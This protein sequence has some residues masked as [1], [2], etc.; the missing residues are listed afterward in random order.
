M[1]KYIDKALDLITTYGP[2]ILLAIVVLLL[3]LWIINRIVKFTRRIMRKRNVD[4]SLQPFLASIINIGLK[5]LLLV[6]VAGMLGFATTSFVAII[7]AAGLAV[8]LALQGTL[9]NFAGGVLILLF[10][11]IR[12][13]DLIEA[14]G[15]FGNVEEIQIFVTKLLTADNKVIIIPNGTLSNGDIVNYTLKGIIRADMLLGI[16]YSSDIKTARNSLLKVMQNHPKI[17]DEPAPFV[18]VDALAD[19][20]VNLSLRAYVKPEDYINLH[21][22]IYEQGKIELE[23]A[24]VQI[25]F[26]QVDVHL[27]K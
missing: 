2:K 17:L 11:P 1:E 7:G 22:D 20:S 19:S 4:D 14:Q 13:G 3:G 26:P 9:A 6:S 5:T 24:G 21:L 16:S 10:K 8:G 27:Q 15:H 25:P 23:K 12:V 18:G